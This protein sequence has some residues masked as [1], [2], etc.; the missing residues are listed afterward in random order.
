LGNRHGGSFQCLGGC[1]LA[2]PRE[3]RR[4]APLRLENKR[5][6]NNMLFNL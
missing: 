3:A 6:L 1:S 4:V 2:Q 5:T